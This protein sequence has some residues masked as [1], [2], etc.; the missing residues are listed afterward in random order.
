[1]RTSLAVIALGIAVWMGILAHTS[2]AA[3]PTAP[4]VRALQGV[5]FIGSGA[6][7]H[8]SMGDPLVFPRPPRASHHPT[9]LGNTTT[10]AVPT[11]G[12]LRAGGSAGKGGGGTA[13]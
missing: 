8:M 11:V 9:L 10:S 3:R 1:M 7:S 12:G 13:A 2:A 5:N 6:F 4:N